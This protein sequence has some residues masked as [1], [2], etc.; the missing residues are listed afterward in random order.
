MAKTSSPEQFPKN[1]LKVSN[2]F[3]NVVDYEI[4]IH[5]LIGFL[6]SSYGHSENII[7]KT[8]QSKLNQKE[9]KQGRKIF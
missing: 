3:S 8:I 9:W 6:C 1:P 5:I 2:K 7:E 4:K